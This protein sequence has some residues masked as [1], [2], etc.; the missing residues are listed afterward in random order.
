MQASAGLLRVTPGELTLIEEYE[1]L[2]N[3]EDPAMAT[4]DEKLNGAVQKVFIPRYR[5][6]FTGAVEALRRELSGRT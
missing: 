4:A 5:T 2:L 1:V 3:G 6:D